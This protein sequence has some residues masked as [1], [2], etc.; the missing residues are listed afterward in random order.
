MGNPPDSDPPA[1]LDWDLWQGPAPARHYNENRFFRGNFRRFWDY[2]G[3]T[4]TDWGVH[5]L[6]IVQ[7]AFG[8]VMP[9]TIVAS[10]GK[11]FTTDN[12]ETPDTMIT[13]YEYPGFVT[14][15]EL[16]ESNAYGVGGGITFHGDKGTLF[17]DR[18]VCRV[19]PEPR[20]DLSPRNSGAGTTRTWFTGPTSSIASV[21]A[22]S[23]RATSNL[24]TARHRQRSW[25][26]SRCAASRGSI[27]TAVQCGRPKPGDSCRGEGPQ[28]LD[29]GGLTGVEP[30]AD[31]ISCFDMKNTSRRQFL[32]AAP[33]GGTLSSAWAA[34]AKPPAAYGTLPSAR[35][36]RW[37]EL[38]VYSF[39][40]FTVNT[41]TDKEWG[42][43]DEDPTIF[44]PPH[45]MPTRL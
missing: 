16:R 27:G 7:M 40:H 25:A 41:F 8:E 45:S 28:A 19:T 38:E 21:L 3:G 31:Y 17:V 5:W 9:S 4:M 6:D 39:L 24:A 44:N 23:Q 30:V 33:L 36:L 37:H 12:R 43:G 34:A 22:R 26:T 14:S 29:A 1:G 13:T 15:F 20:S 32:F 11:L 18:S 35:Q 42:Y 2:A 10:G